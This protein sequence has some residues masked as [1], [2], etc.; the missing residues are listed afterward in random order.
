MFLFLA[1]LCFFTLKS[2]D[3][4]RGFGVGLL[5]MATARRILVTIEPVSNR[6]LPRDSAMKKEE[7]NGT[8]F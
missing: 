5:L 7:F 3:G 6:M 2:C 8:A 4:R 1:A